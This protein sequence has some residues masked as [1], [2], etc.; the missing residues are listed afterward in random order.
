M[1]KK[2]E[3]ELLDLATWYH[4]N[5]NNEMSIEMR[6]KFLTRAVDVL[7]WVVAGNTGDIQKIEHRGNQRIIFPR[8]YVL[9]G[10]RRLRTPTGHHYTE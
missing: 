1:S 4:K 5:K 7:I 9:P 8:D 10:G 2:T 6:L 3:Q